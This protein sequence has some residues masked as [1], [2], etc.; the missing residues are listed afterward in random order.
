RRLA[1]QNILGSFQKADSMENQSYFYGICEC[2]CRICTR[3]RPGSHGEYWNFVCLY[4]GVYRNHCA[5]QNQ[6]GYTQTVQSSFSASDPNFG[7]CSLCGHDGFT[8]Y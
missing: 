3:I 1:A 5:A 6:S 2:V 4:P 8:T 7:Y